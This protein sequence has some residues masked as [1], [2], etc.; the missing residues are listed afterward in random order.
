MRIPAKDRI[1]FVVD[2]NSFQEMFVDVKLPNKFIDSE[3][4]EKLVKAENVS[5]MDEAVITGTAKVFGEKIAIVVCDSS[6]MMGSMG[7]VVGERITCMIDYATQSNLP[8][9][10]FCCSGGARMQ[11]GLRSLM[12]MEK[13]A[14][15][16]ARHSDKSL[17]C[18]TILTDPTTGGVTASFAM[19]GDVIM[20]ERDTTIGFAGKRVIKQTIGRE[21]P[22][23]FQSAE[24]QLEHGMIDGIV[25]RKRMRKMIQFLTITNRQCQRYDGFV[26]RNKLRFN[27]LYNL[28]EKKSN[29]SAWQKV[30]MNRKYDIYQ[31]LDFI[32]DIFDVFVELKGDRLYGDDSSIAG[33]LAL[34]SGQPVTVIATR[35]GKNA[36]EIIANNYGMPSPEGYRKA[37]RL[38]RQ[39]EKYNRPIITFINTPG[40]YPGEEAEERGQG[41]AIARNLFEMSKLT[42]PILAIIVG[43][44]GSGGALA[45]AVANEVWMLENATYSILSP[46]G[47][48]SIVWKDASR[49]EEAAEKMNIT[50]ESLKKNEVIDKIIRCGDNEDT[51]RMKECSA[52]IKK[53]IEEFLTRMSKLDRDT[54]KILREERFR[55]Y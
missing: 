51:D 52:H 54:I 30:K 38:M 36:Q 37:L 46:E 7:Y 33:G 27:R 9:F 31:P 53:E 3:Y 41:E 22:A 39:A 5:G 43:E 47:Y 17:F 20:A 45:L 1:S 28:R 49:A 25:E 2:K 48:A 40:A 15:A 13:T 21:L 12:Q 26:D 10:I 42:V 24:F 14:S 35:R 44:A 23:S 8:I 34:L 11:E 32:R 29:I 19:L 16:L 4:Q 6:F 18:S 55:K 50:A